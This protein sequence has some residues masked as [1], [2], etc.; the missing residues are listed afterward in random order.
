MVQSLLPSDTV[1]KKKAVVHDADQQLIPKSEQAYGKYYACSSPA[2]LAHRT[3]DGSL[4]V[5][6]GVLRAYSSARAL[7]ELDTDCP[8]AVSTSK[9][10]HVSRDLG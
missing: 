4:L 10:E 2:S 6:Y 3:C 9:F 7:V 8:V 5:W 1:G